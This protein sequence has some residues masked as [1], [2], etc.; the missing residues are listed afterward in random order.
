MRFSALVAAVALAAPLAASSLA[1]AVP[2]LPPE[3]E[4]AADEQ[5]STDP[6]PTKTTAPKRDAGSAQPSSGGGSG[7]GAAPSPAPSGGPEA[8]TPA[9][10]NACGAAASQDACFQCCET[11]NPNALPVLDQAWGDCQCDVPG[12][13]AGVCG[14]QFCGGQPTTLG[15]S[16]DN[17]LAANDQSCG[18]KAETKCAAD[19]KCKPYLTC[20]TDAKCASKPL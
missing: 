1:C 14:L 9:P 8:G 3:D 2:N 6:T 11:A 10:T 4:A 12:T 15:S 16:C 7:S 18:T 17:C 20:T 5:A 19:S 13:C